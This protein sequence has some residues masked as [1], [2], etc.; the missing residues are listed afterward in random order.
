MADEALD[1]DDVASEADIA[2]DASPPA[3]SD[4]RKESEKSEKQTPNGDA[5]ESDMRDTEQD[6]V[7]VKKRKAVI[8]SDDD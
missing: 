2:T 8:D 6:V 5:N 7:K 1:M 4:A 3:S